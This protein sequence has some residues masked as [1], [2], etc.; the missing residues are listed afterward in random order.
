MQPV[1]A[2][3][4]GARPALGARE[5]CMRTTT[6][7]GQRL[8]A[9]DR[10]QRC[11]ACTPLALTPASC[12]RFPRQPLRARLQKKKW[13]WALLDTYQ[14]PSPFACAKGRTIRNNDQTLLRIFVQLLKRPE[15]PRKT[16][17]IIPVSV[18]R[19]ERGRER[20]KGPPPHSLH[21]RRAGGHK[22]SGRRHNVSVHPTPF[23]SHTLLAGHCISL[24]FSLVNS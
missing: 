11:L 17:L 2:H 16:G 19:R 5:R 7:R 22:P 6:A 14:A 18:G 12:R 15:R 20:D 1:S 23:H 3:A 4:A 21:H 10:A 24:M 13:A 8:C 9:H